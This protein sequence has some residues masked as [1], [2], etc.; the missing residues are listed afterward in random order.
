MM[1]VARTLKAE[2]TV[3]ISIGLDVYS[4]MN[5]PRPITG[6]ETKLVIV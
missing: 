1:R 4:V 3:T 6:L 2:R 5:V